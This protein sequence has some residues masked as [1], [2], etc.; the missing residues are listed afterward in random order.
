MTDA[1]TTERW[2]EA[3]RRVF[4]RALGDPAF[5]Q[6]A[7]SDGRAAFTEAN[8]V[9][10]PEGVKFR[11]AEALDEH[12]Y[13]L[14]KTIVTQGE[15]SEIDVARVLHHSFRQQSVPPAFAR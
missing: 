9:P 3:I 5:R 8:G 2:E 13:V 11:F 4:R 6:L 14:P 12:V 1:W 7:L 15:L 10:P